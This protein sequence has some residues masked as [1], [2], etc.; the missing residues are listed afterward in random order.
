LH[1]ELSCAGPLLSPGD[2][3]FGA[4]LGLT[5]VL[6]PLAPFKDKLTMLAGLECRAQSPN[7]GHS[8]GSTGF[9]CGFGT[10]VL[11]TKGGPSLD[12]VVHEDAQTQLDLQS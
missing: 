2:A 6:A 3:G 4:R 10:E 5:G 11:S 7:N 9:A 12:W 1:V 8:H